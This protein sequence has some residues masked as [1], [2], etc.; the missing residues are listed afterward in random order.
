MRGIATI[1]LIATTTWAAS[2]ALAKISCREMPGSAEQPLPD[3]P[4]PCPNC[5]KKEAPTGPTLEVDCC[6]VQA[7]SE[8]PPAEPVKRQIAVEDSRLALLPEM[9]AL[10]SPCESKFRVTPLTASALPPPLQLN[11]PLLC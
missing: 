5:P 7:A 2:P 4:H 9:P 11:R 1:V 3:C 8:V 10:I 6:I